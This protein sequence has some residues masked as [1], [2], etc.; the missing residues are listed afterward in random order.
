MLT[1]IILH[2]L[3]MM[4]IFSWLYIFFIINRIKTATLNINKHLLPLVHKHAIKT[5]WGNIKTA[6]IIFIAHFMAFKGHD[7]RILGGQCRWQHRRGL[8]FKLHHSTIW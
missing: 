4:P 3:F 6:G 1:C 7:I 2:Q 5:T 8:H